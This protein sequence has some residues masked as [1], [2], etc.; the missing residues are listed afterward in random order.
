MSSMFITQCVHTTLTT[1]FTQYNNTGRHYEAHP[2]MKHGNGMG[3]LPWSRRAR[4]VLRCRIRPQRC[5][6]WFAWSAR[7][8]EKDKVHS[9]DTDR[10]Q[11]TVT[12]A[13]RLRGKR[14]LWPRFR[15][16]TNLVLRQQLLGKR[17]DLL[18]GG[19]VETRSQC[20]PSS[21]QPARRSSAVL[22]RCFVLCAKQLFRSLCPPRA[23]RRR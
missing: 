14:T 15:N 23:L 3:F 19:R 7:D 9:T 16:Q 6:S 5:V 18:G 11:N 20:K 17:K 13:A 4:G 2:Q 12:R 10:L 1:G 21:P 8:Q 22:S